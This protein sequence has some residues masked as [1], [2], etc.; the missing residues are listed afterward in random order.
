MADLTAPFSPDWCLAPAAT[1]RSALTDRSIKVRR[2]RHGRLIR[3]VLAREPLTAKHADALWAVTG[4]P[5]RFWLNHE[6]IY[7]DGLA[8]GLSDVTPEDTDA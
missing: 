1:L 3:E 6:R 8:A 4:V 2:G 7:R 5:A